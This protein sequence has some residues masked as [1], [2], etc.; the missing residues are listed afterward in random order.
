VRECDGLC[1]DEGS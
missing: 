1:E